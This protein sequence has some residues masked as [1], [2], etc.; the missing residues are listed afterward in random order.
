MSKDSDVSNKS[1]TPSP[2]GREGAFIDAS[3][4]PSALGV[5]PLVG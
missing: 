1:H 4:Q 5:R 3:Y 2:E